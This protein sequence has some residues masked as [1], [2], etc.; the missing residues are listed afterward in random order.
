MLTIDEWE[1][2]NFSQKVTKLVNRNILIINWSTSFVLLSSLQVGSITNFFAIYLIT[3]FTDA[4]F[5]EKEKY[6]AICDDL[7]GTFAELT[8]Y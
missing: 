8:G 1:C 2:Y 7:D 4:L 3:N 5:N 6:K